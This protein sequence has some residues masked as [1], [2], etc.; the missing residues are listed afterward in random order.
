MHQFPTLSMALPI[1]MSLIKTIYHIRSKYNVAQLI[2]AAD[3]MIIKLKK[4]LVLA[5]KKPVPICSMILDPQ[6]KL[7]HLEKNQAF[8]VEHDIATLTINQALQI[9]SI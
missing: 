3:D 6:I 7:K 9:N 5:L 2:P 1:Y 8:L 4:Y